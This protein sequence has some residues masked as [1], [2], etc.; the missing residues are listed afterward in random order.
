MPCKLSPAGVRRFSATIGDLVAIDVDSSGNSAFIFW[1][2]YAGI[3][4]S[5]S[6]NGQ[7][8]F[9]VVAGDEAMSILIEDPAV[10]V[11]NVVERCDD[12][13][14]NTLDSLYFNTIGAYQNYTIAGE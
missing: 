9:T 7:W 2:S 11:V 10:G 12:G 8:T 3:D 13:S 4:L 5:K 6:T 14:N 1:A